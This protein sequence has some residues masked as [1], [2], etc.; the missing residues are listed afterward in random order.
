ML[1]PLDRMEP[2]MCAAA[3]ELIANKK[4]YSVREDQSERVSDGY[5]FSN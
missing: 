4:N 1:Q 2:G 3:Q 5:G